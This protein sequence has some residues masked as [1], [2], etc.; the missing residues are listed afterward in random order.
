[1]QPRK[2]RPFKHPSTTPNKRGLYVR[3]WRGTTVLPEHDRTLS[4]DLW[5]PLPVGDV[6][7]PG[8]WYVWPG[9]NDASYQQLP[10][11]EATEAE[12]E[13]FLLESLGATY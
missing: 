10:W 12:K 3:D 4:V 11:R 2:P 6:L 13:R 1:M 5:E 8:V 9:W 7:A